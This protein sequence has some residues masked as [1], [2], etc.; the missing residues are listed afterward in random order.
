MEEQGTGFMT[1]TVRTAGGALPVEN[2]SV[3]VSRDGGEVIAV[4]I[5]DNAG[6]SSVIE[7]PAPPRENSLTPNGGQVSSFYTVDA[8]RDG[9]YEV[10]VSS[11]PIFDGVTS[12]QQILLV[13]IAE[14]DA[15]LQPNDLTRFSVSGSTEL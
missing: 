10:I 7:L 8:Y 15:P 3:A 9:F 6:R 11:I 4:L 5:T 2:V 1:V 12:I 13:P 14:G